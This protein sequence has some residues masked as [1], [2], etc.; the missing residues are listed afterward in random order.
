MSALDRPS[1]SEW[2]ER[3]S[4]CSDCRDRRAIVQQMEPL[5]IDLAQAEQ[6]VLYPVLGKYLGF[7]E[8]M[9]EAHAQH[10]GIRDLIQYARTTSDPE[11]ILEI[12][13]EL[14]ARLAQY[15]N[16]MRNV[17]YPRLV[18]TLNRP[19]LAELKSRLGRYWIFDEISIPRAA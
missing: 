19:E 5:L 6:D 8:W 13:D 15:L 1:I 14:A 3:L 2:I 9:Q 18:Q 17:L 7:A 12:T 10:C 16:G 4:S 11:H